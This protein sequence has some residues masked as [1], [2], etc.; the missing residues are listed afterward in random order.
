MANVDAYTW[1][2]NHPL[3]YCRRDRKGK[4]EKGVSLK[5]IVWKA[6]F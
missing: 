2:L 4:L 5:V 6:E 1:Y 3:Q